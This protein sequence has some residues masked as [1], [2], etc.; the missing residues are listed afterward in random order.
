MNKEEQEGSNE[1]TEVEGREMDP[2]YIQPKVEGGKK[3]AEIS[4]MELGIGT[5]EATTLKPAKVGIKVVEIQELGEK[6]SKK[7]VC[8]CKHPGKEENISISSIKYE[9]KG[10]LEV[11]GLW[12]NKDSQGLIR[13]G[14]AL[15]VFLNVM[16][17]SKVEDLEN[18]EI[19][20]AQDEKGY[21]CFKGY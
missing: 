1:L 10:K 18:K 17:C 2:D 6:K 20:T 16:G 12:V 13:K 7:V 8:H 5:E 3:M 4:E 9:N 15:A 19:Q 11:S 21:L 14:S